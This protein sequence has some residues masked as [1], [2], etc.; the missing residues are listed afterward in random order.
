[1]NSSQAIDLDTTFGQ[2]FLDVAEGQAVAQIPAHRHH[3]HLGRN[4]KP[5]NADRDTGTGRQRDE[6]LT[7]PSSPIDNR[8]TQQRPET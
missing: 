7:D 8:R 3:D 4:R 2:Q 5:A 1:M 6:K